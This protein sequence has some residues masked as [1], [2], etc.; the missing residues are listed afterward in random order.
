MGDLSPS[1]H[2]VTTA[3]LKLHRLDEGEY[4]QA[5]GEF[6]VKTFLWSGETGL[7]GIWRRLSS[8]AEPSAR[9]KSDQKFFIRHHIKLHQHA[10]FG[11][12]WTEN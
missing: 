2:S 11:I 9:E 8:S 12:N 7:A 5:M 6:K 3:G 4:N 10:G 1:H